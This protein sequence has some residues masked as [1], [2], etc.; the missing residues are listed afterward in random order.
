M[1]PPRRPRP[2]RSGVVNIP[3]PGM[4]EPPAARP[5][6]PRQPR[7]ERLQAP[8][9]STGGDLLPKAEATSQEFRESLFGVLTG[10]KI[11]GSGR[12]D[13]RAQLIAAFGASARDSSRPNTAAAAKGLG[14]SQRSV[15]RWLKTGG[16]LSPSH[17]KKLQ[18]RARQAMTTKRGRQQAL[19]A[20]QRA[21]VKPRPPGMGGRGLKVGGMQGVTSSLEGDYRD[22]DTA[23]IIKDEE[24]QELR[25]VWAEG[26][27]TAAA[28]WL[29]QH[30][31]EHYVGKWHFKSIDSIEWTDT[32]NY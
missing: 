14:V 9:R 30:W 32:K 12:G 1:T 6:E 2:P 7:A 5:A 8:T 24:L 29:H 13:V 28:A 25:G 27:D 18:R 4:P 31:D 20:T 26:G 15:Q 23:V 19:A 10:R 17:N 16:G 3:L 21:G 22:R 11:K